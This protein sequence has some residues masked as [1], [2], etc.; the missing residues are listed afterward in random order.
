MSDRYASFD[1][2]IA[3]VHDILCHLAYVIKCHKMTFYGILGHLA[4]AIKCHELGQYGYQMK[5]IDQ[6]K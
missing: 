6:T 1:T 5:R 4:D 2:H 3:I